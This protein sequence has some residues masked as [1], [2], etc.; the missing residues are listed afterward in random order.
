MNNRKKSIFLTSILIAS[1]GQL[2]YASNE[3]DAIFFNLNDIVYYDATSESCVSSET[4]NLQ[5][6]D[7]TEKAW[8]FFISQGF[9]KEATAG[10]LG[11]FFTE[12]SVNPRRYETDY[13]FTDRYDQIAKD[14]SIEGG[15]GITWGEFASKYSIP[16]NEA[17]YADAGDGKHY[18]GIGLG[19]WTG[20]R[21]RMLIQ[22]ARDNNLDVWDLGAQLKFMLEGDSQSRIDQVTAMKSMNTTPEEAANYFMRTWE[23]VSFKVSERQ[24]AARTIFE[25]YKNSSSD[26]NINSSDTSSSNDDSKKSDSEK[27]NSTSSTTTTSTKKSGCGGGFSSSEDVTR[28]TS[29]GFPIFLQT[30]ERWADEEYAPAYGFKMGYA[31]CGPTS[32]AMITTALGVPKSPLEVA[33]KATEIGAVTNGGASNSQPSML[34]K[35]YGLQA[36]SISHRSIDEINSHLD[37]GHLIWMGGTTIEPPFTTGGHIIVIR[38][39]TASGKWLIANPYDYPY[40]KDIDKS[41]M[42]DM[43]EWDPSLIT[44]YSNTATAVWK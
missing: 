42:D 35:E 22:Y 4:Y 36:K 3:F 38:K 25:M 28:T 33:K 32:F 40:N 9:S 20:V 18:L 2:V 10:I 12:S 21:N 7:N 39:K 43:Y 8:N 41:Q 37:Q 31:A 24:S 15:L 44:K 23:G 6:N 27:D 34:A 17:G 13:I 1:I 30:D 26:S 11:N 16:L 5:G 29:D 19:Q 14:S